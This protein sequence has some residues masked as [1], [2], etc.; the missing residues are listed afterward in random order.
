VNPRINR[1]SFNE[2]VNGGKTQNG[3]KNVDD[4]KTQQ[5]SRNARIHP[6]QAANYVLREEDYVGV[7]ASRT[8]F[9]DLNEPDPLKTGQQTRRVFFNLCSRDLTKVTAQLVNNIGRRQS[10]R[11]GGKLRPN[12]TAD[13]DN[14]VNLV[15]RDVKNGAAI[16][17]TI[18]ADIR[19]NVEAY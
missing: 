10:F 13:S 5:G 4:C 14:A 8:C 17:I 19:R 7:R 16:L 18:R 6:E 11:G 12:N 3:K 9:A 15:L 1:P 2:V